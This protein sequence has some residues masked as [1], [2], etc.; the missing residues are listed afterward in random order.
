MNGVATL[1]GSGKVPTSQLPASATLYKGTWN[2]STNTPSISNATGSTGYLYIVSVAGTQNL[3]FGSLTFAVGDNV[4][5]NGSIYQIITS[6][7]SVTSVNGS[8]GTV[9]LTTSNITEGT[10]LYYTNARTIAA[11]LTGYIT[12]TNIALSSG[13]T[14]LTA[15]QNIQAQL[16]AKES[17]VTA[18]TSSQYYR[19]D[20]TWVTLDQS[21][22][23][24][25]NVNNT[26][27]ANKP[28]SSAT[29]TALNLKADLASPTF[30]GT[31]TLPTGTIGVTQTAGNSTTAVATT[32]FVTG[33]ITTGNNLK[34]NVASP[35]FTGTVIMP[36]GTVSAA[37]LKMVAGTN[38]TTPVAG[39]IEFDGTNLFYTNSTPT[40]L[41]VGN[42]ETAQ[43]FTG[44]KTFTTPILG[45]ATA[46]SINKVAITAP[47]T[48]ATLTIADGKTLLANNTLTLS[49]TDGS[50]LNIGTGGT[51][52]TNAYTSTAYAPLASPALT[53]VPTAPT[54]A[55]SDN[56]TTVAT[57]AFVASAIA[58]SASTRVV[59]NA[60]VT[61]ATNSFADVTGLSFPVVAGTYHFKFTIPYTSAATA[62]G[63]KWSINGS[64]AATRLNYTC[65]WTK[66]ATTNQIYNATAYNTGSASSTSLTNGNVC[67]IEGIAVFTSSGTI[68]ARFSSELNSGSSTITALSGATVVYTK[69]Q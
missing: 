23:G 44:V 7:Q 40:R 63:S 3:G 54:A 5:H 31:P 49:G 33:A 20:K 59:M 41:T 39:S 32:A 14:V 21:A 28:V 29:Q 18:G 57:T 6:T 19:G 61:N 67:L 48:G 13:N 69:I 30:T 25:A 53:G 60:N 51:L 24:L 22:V 64:V 58:S 8:Q 9:V 11:P 43:T 36:T 27:D 68:I 66:A 38:L 47:A 55:L 1:D 34:A 4:I 45:A 52:G 56:S 10:N 42:L 62:T 2:A 50:T 37:P 15:F 12:G 65:L 46:T 26:S 16:N 35:T 17:T